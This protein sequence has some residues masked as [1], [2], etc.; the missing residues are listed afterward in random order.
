MGLLG[1][2]IMLAALTIPASWFAAAAA[3]AAKCWALL[4][5]RE[6]GLLWMRE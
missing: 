2:G 1:G 5:R 3:A 4:L 6:L